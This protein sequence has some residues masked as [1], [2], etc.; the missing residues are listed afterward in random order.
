MLKQQIAKCEEKL[1]VLDV[2]QSKLQ[3]LECSTAGKVII[4]ARDWNNLLSRVVLLETQLLLHSK[5]VSQKFILDVL[6]SSA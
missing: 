1:Q 5:K 4:D 2:I 3:A 6:C